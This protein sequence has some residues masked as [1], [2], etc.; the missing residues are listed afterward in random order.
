M[1][2]NPLI[3]WILSAAFS[4]IAAREKFQR[5]ADFEPSRTRSRTKGK[6]GAPGSKLARK[7]EKHAIGMRHGISGWYAKGSPIRKQM[8]W[9]QRMRLA[10]NGA[11]K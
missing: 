10:R 3:S 7:A 6:P 4:M 9:S 1:K 11:T 2:R 5:L 8:N